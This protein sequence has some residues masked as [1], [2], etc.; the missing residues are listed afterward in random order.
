MIQLS[1]TLE[2]FLLNA[3]VANVGRLVRLLSG[4]V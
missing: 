2:I 4:G 1:L 3:D